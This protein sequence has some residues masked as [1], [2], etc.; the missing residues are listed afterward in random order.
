M[1][2]LLLSRHFWVVSLFALLTSVH[3]PF[4]SCEELTLDR[5]FGSQSLNGEEVLNLKISP[6]GTRVTYLRGK[7]SDSRN[8]ELWEYNMR[9]RTNRILVD[10]E[11][12]LA[13]KEV[14][15]EE[16][17]SRR[18]RQRI[19]EY[20][21][22]D[23]YWD[24]EKGSALLFPLGGDVYYKPVDGNVKRLTNTEAFETD[25]KISPNGSY[26][27]FI[28]DQDIFVIDLKS[29]KEIQLTS[30]GEGAI[31]NGVAEFI[32]AEEM[33]RY[34]GYWWSRDDAYIAFTRIDETPV[35][36]LTRYEV[37][38]DGRVTTI[39][40][41]YPLA[42]TPN[43]L[44]QLGV[45]AIPSGK[46]QWID[47]GPDKDIY[48]A[49]VQWLPD[50]K[51]LAYQRQPRNQK[52]IDLIFVDVHNA[53]QQQLVLSETSDTWTNLSDDLKFLEH[54]DSFVWTSERD[55]FRHLYLYSQDGKLIRQLTSGNW[56]V[57]KVEEVDEKGGDVYFV[58]KADSILET[59][60]YAVPIKG[61]PWR[62]IT[63]ERGTHDPEVSV[64]GRFFVDTY[65]SLKSP[66][67]PSIHDLDGKLIGVILNNALDSTHP[68]FPFLS[69]HVERSF[70]SLKTHN[71]VTLHYWLMKPRNLDPSKKYPAVILVYGGPLSQQVGDQWSLG[72]SQYLARN[73]YIVFCL[74]NRGSANRGKAFEDV[75]YR[76][77]GDIEV[78]DQLRGL[79][80][81]KSV[82]FVDPSRIGV[83]GW[84]YGG[85]M[86]LQ[87]LSKAPGAFAAGFSGA[88]VT[89]WRLY[90]TH[91][92]ERYL[93]NPK[94]EPE[95]YER[96]SVF[97]F[98]E[99]LRADLL[100]IHGMADDNVFFDH[101]V[102]LMA[103]LEKR[104]KLFELMT[105][106]G[107]RHGIYGKEESIH[108]WKTVFDFFER[109]LKNRGPLNQT[110]ANEN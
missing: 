70:G 29:G 88:P 45:I 79:E 108:S 73:G 44:I 76:K 106:P 6:D 71:G 96:S 39:A 53:M 60:L 59:H 1:T 62:K 11:D 102:R 67:Q 77:F 90:D 33:G 52:R 103:E 94:E 46:I 26:V 15:S 93:G 54:S 47:L 105:Y 27:S 50:S 98:S 99:K 48:L 81:L 56:A 2:S 58:G 66:P 69:E 7:K 97:P 9:D 82:S 5:L 57:M 19:S 8:L 22:V 31:S 91:Y 64:E 35:H 43:V 92:T 100:L 23:Y 83:Y 61:G 13:G 72:F 30:D 17:K 40:Q 95:A 51:R 104:G 38:A 16:E 4:A 10:S 37:A 80:F 84:S 63:K 42:G 86:T 20:G 14:L 36:V 65:S 21:I 74:D 32:A 34:T 49:N 87:L 107:Q 41:R 109:K 78:Q 25:P 3:A 75:L 89:D 68:Y 24:E 28:R 12:F 18:E 55:G 110:A 85:Y 101:S